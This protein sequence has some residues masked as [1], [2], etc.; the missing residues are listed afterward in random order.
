MPKA[1]SFRNAHGSQQWSHLVDV[2]ATS[3]RCGFCGD[4]VCSER[5]L[6]YH[7]QGVGQT[8]EPGILICPAC[9]APTFVYPT[10]NEL[11]PG[12]SIGSTVSHV[13]AVLG[14]L[15]EEARGCA[16]AN[17]YTAAVLL[18]RKVLMHIAVAQ[19]AKEGLPFIEYVDYLVRTGYVPPN[20]KHW[21]D[22]IRKKGNEANHEIVIMQQQEAKDLITFIEML[23]RFIYE[24]P[25][26][27]PKAS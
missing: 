18:C 3:Y 25:N 1:P 23:L 17:H 4:Q 9:K 20:G 24:F 5:G 7:K 21:V 12:T 13:P 2:T 10:S 26:S 22:H 15:Y 8:K 14:A 27:I 11:F 6:P 16:T 19:G